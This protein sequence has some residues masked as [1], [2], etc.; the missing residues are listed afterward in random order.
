[1]K[2]GNK[3]YRV[4]S[5]SSTNDL[6]AEL[7]SKGESEGTVVIAEEQ[8]KG[9]GRKG[10]AWF[11]AGKTGLYLSV[12][13]RPHT[14]D[15]SLLPLAAGIA[16]SDAVFTVTGLRIRLRWPND[17]VF[18][19]WK[20]GGILCESSFLGNQLSYVILGIGLNTRHSVEDF[21]RD[22]R[23]T[24]TSLKLLGGEDVDEKELLLKLCDALGRWYSLF[25]R[26][27]EGRIIRTFEDYSAVPLG[28]KIA[29]TAECG[30]FSGPFC[31]IDTKGRLILEI[32]GKKRSFS[33]AEIIDA[34]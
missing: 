27:E 9:R 32:G 2:I 24:A 1:M 16:V 25:L 11:S 13:L 6:A 30:L 12:I 21:P 19:E 23:S 7:A 20:L 8:R 34:A 15:I 22:L 10:R 17:L 31:G 33:A 14:T 3:I 5:C 18:D 4:K 26:R 29:V 28:K